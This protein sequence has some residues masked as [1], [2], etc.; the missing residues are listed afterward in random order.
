MG[1]F[2]L[3][4]QNVTTL[5]GIAI[6]VNSA[7]ATLRGITTDVGPRQSA[8]ISDVC[9]QKRSFFDGVSHRFAIEGH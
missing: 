1:P 8:N 5:D 9:H 4:G 2:C 3:Q 7:S 6:K